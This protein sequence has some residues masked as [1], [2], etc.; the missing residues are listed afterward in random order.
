MF[1][2]FNVPK[3]ES[4]LQKSL[5]IFHPIMVYYH[6]KKL[7]WQKQNSV[8]WPHT[9][10]K[11]KPVFHSWQ[12]ILLSRPRSIP[13]GT[14]FNLVRLRCT[15]KKKKKKDQKTDVPVQWRS[16]GAADRLPC[17]VHILICWLRICG[18]PQSA[19]RSS[20]SPSKMTQ[21]PTVLSSSRLALP[22]HLQQTQ[23]VI[24]AVKSNTREKQ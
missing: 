14:Q 17:M 20:H 5:E 6:K 2:C 3:W 10:H 16:F 1:W 24:K 8:L 7:C 15:S 9:Q 22:Q 18:S 23:E 13:K 12:C 19:F 21:W 4:N 11:F